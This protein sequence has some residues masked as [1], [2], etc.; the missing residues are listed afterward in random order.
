MKKSVLVIGGGFFGLYLAEY[1]AMKGFD[2][3]LCEKEADFM[4]R[5]SYANQARVHSGY[6]Y[7]RSVLTALR[8]LKS[9][10]RFTRE[11]PDCIDDEFEKFYA[12]G[13]ILS[14]VTARQFELFCARIGA[15]CHPAP[16]QVTKLIN[17][18]YIEA[19][20]STVECAF[21]AVK[22]SR[23]MVDRVGNA[24][25]ETSCGTLVDHVRQVEGGLEVELRQV[26]DPA[27]TEIRTFQQV[28]NCT[29]SMTNY[30]LE[31][32]GLPLIPL[33]HEMTEMCLIE[34]PDELRRKGI[35]VMCGPF[36]SVMP[37][38]PLGLHTL[39]HVRYTPHYAWHDQPEHP[40]LNAHEHF[41]RTTQRTAWPS[42]LRD[43]QRYLPIIAESAYRDSIWEVKTVLP[44]SE[45]DDSRPILFRPNHGIPGLHSIMGGK[46]D[47]VYDVLGVVEEMGLA[48]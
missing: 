47:N 45:T 10:P 38:P 37:F 28:F 21:D 24:G 33:K 41:A 1:F 2:V 6:H 12:V 11:F 8:S 43:C 32:S 25:V 35:T 9:Y 15:P 27:Q 13:R 29:Y 39:S 16:Y 19:V 5:A 22:L 7:P 20:F 36:F 14:K 31:R 17:P 4:Q 48:S 46:I 40:Y 30:I 18:H 42:M 3:L 34:V 44:R 23:A 26:D